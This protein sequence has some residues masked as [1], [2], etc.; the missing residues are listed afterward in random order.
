MTMKKILFS[1]LMTAVCSTASA[2]DTLTVRKLF[3][4][5]PDS[6]VPYLSTNNRLDMIDFMDSHMKAEVTND[7][8]GKSLMT[9]LTDDSLSIKLSEAC[10]LDMLLLTSTQ[11]IDS[12]RQV[13]MLVRSF[14]IDNESMEATVE[15][16]S[17]RWHRLNSTPTLI[18]IDKNRILSH[19]KQLSIPNYI[20]NKLNK[21]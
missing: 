12:C 17:A 21:D 11:E 5:I 4:E 9:A 1:C 8:G 15:Y 3:I 2:A 18:P 16:Y 10:N 13:V 20:Q 19:K 14:V 7:L 6:V